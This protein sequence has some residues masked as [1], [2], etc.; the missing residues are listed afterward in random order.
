[1][2]TLPDS[3]QITYAERD[4]TGGGNAI[5]TCEIQQQWYTR[6]GSLNKT[7]EV[8]KVL[9]KG[10]FLTFIFG[11]DNE[12]MLPAPYRRQS[13]SSIS[14]EFAFLHAHRKKSYFKINASFMAGEF[15]DDTHE[16]LSRYFPI[17]CEMLFW[18]M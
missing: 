18:K 3:S 6:Q 12:I 1:M 4:G 9:A 14:P 15:Q 10:T 13:N 17:F 8:A 2:M 16:V 7:G 11:D 5:W